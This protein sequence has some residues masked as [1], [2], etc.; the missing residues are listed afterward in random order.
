LANGNGDEK[1]Y[2]RMMSIEMQQVQTMNRNYHED[3]RVLTWLFFAFL[4]D[5]LL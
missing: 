5:F 2:S 4:K 3:S 1:N